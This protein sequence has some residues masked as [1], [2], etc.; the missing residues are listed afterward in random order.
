MKNQALFSWK[1]KSKKLI[2]SLLQFLFGTLRLKE[3]EQT[4][5]TNNKSLFRRFYYQR[6]KEEVINFAQFCENDGKTLDKVFLTPLIIGYDVE[7]L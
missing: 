4:I 6:N 2:C 3:L 1:G 5:P 7:V